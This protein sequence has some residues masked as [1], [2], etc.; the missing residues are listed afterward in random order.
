MALTPRENFLR[1][2]SMT[3][4]EW[5]PLMPVIS[6]AS[7]IQLGKEL[8]DV[9]ARHPL[10]FP[11]FEPGKREYA[12]PN[13][14]GL[15]EIDERTTDNWGCTWHRS[16]EG[17]VG[18]VEGHPL[19]DWEKLE[20]YRAPD[21]LTQDSV[22]SVD[23]T[24][25]RRN[26]ETQRAQ[27]ELTFGELGHGFLFMRLYDLRGFDNLM[28]DYATDEPNLR[29]L[30]DLLTAHF[31]TVVQQYLNIGV[32][33]ISAGDDLGT[34]EAS[35]ISPV[36]FRKW[37]VP[38][39]QQLFLPA[40]QAG[41]HVLLH[42]D[43]HMIELMDEIIDAG[44]TICNPQDLC[45][46]LREIKEAVDG[47]IAV[48]LDIDRQTIVPYGT[49]KEIRDHVEECVRILGSPRGGLELV[50]G[51]YPPTPPE[52]IDAL[53]SAFEEFRTYWFDGRGK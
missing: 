27:G 23:W 8:E 11:D 26:I 28:I 53:F 34:Q 13:E 1:N 43:G 2:A 17:I 44:V 35:L 7:W 46:G 30:I 12:S 31:K 20:T 15:I 37:I 29:K 52:N 42:S 14:Y 39:Y 38:A 50:V 49:P 19:D 3:G 45:N 41:R 4:P 24:E 22:S 21:P 6:A 16:L 33:L 36:M 5:M 48:R 51:I 40:R 18:V 47:R 10:L 9:L 25:R 32:D